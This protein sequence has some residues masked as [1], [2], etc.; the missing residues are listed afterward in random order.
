MMLTLP[1]LPPRPACSSTKQNPDHFSSDWDPFFQLLVQFKQSRGHCNVPAHHL[2]SGSKLWVW[3]MVQKIQRKRGT[4]DNVR[5][6]LL[7]SLGVDWENN[8]QASSWDL[9]FLLLL[10]FR[11]REGH[12]RVPRRHFEDGQ[13]LGA[14]I[15][16]HR[17]KKKAGTLVFEKERR[18]NEIGF[19]WKGHEG[20]WDTM[21]RALI[22]YKQRE[23]HLRVPTTHVE[24]GQK[25]GDWIT[26]HRAKK[27]AGTLVSEKERRL[28]EIGFIWSG[29]ERQW[30]TM[31]KSLIQFKQREGH[32]KV[33]RRHVEHWNVSDQD[34][35]NGEVKDQLGAWLMNQRLYHVRGTLDAKRAMRL[36]SVGV[37]WNCKQR[38]AIVTEEDFDS[39]FDLLL[40]FKEREGHVQVPLKHQE[41]ATDF[42][43]AWL[44]IQRSK[45]R[46]GLLAL[47]RQKWLEVAGVKW[48]NKLETSYGTQTSLLSIIDAASLIDRGY[49]ISHHSCR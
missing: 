31:F 47:D 23:G 19:I 13:Q 39:N 43:G 18:L 17:A 5:K 30:E 36:E 14:W 11:D 22:H 37:K 21:F 15:C 48:E 2:E 20:K 45:Y 46:Q 29:H 3:L 7:E 35:E 44:E 32:L 8:P 27:K 12:L 28:N 34:I 38:Q 1:Y 42:L 26:I 25:L 4:M 24:D 10:Q 16:K 49:H 6:H 41:K 33:P 9:K 40:A